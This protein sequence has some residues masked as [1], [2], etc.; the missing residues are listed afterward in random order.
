MAPLDLYVHGTDILDR[1]LIVLF[2]PLAPTRKR[3]FFG[4]FSLA[5][6]WKR[7]ISGYFSVFLAIFGLFFCCLPPEIFLPTPLSV[8][9]SS[10][11]FGPIVS[12][13]NNKLYVLRGRPEE[14]HFANRRLS[15]LPTPQAASSSSHNHRVCCLKPVQS[16]ITESRQTKCPIRRVVQGKRS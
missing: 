3:L 16:V 13:D 4:L 7:L 8:T 12:S 11:S 6:T 9:T 5:P 15:Q 2:F 1:G 10:S 14:C